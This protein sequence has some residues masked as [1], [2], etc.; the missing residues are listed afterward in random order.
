MA[1]GDLSARVPLRRR[2][3]L[4]R[5]GVALNRMAERLGEIVERER[6]KRTELEQ[7]VT[8]LR[9]CSEAVAEGRLE[10]RAAESDD[11]LGRLAAGF[12]QMVGHVQTLVERERAIQK[13][14][15]ANHAVLESANARLMEVDRRKSDFLNTVSHELRTPLTSIKAFSEI[16]LEQEPGEADRE[17]LGIIDQEADRLTRL[18]EDLLDLSRIE[19]GEA[20]GAM[21][22]LPL[23]VVVD[24]CL[25]SCRAL[26]SQKGVHLVRLSGGEAVVRGDRDRLAQVVTNLLSNAIKFT[27]PGGEVRV[28]T[29]RV[30]GEAVIAVTDTGVGIPEADLAR[31]FE[32]FQQVDRGDAGSGGSGLGLPIVRSIVEAHRGRIAVESVPG[33]G[34]TF[35][36]H[37]PEASPSAGPPQAPPES[38]RGAGEPPPKETPL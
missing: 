28:E 36:V 2:D 1:N 32:K 23:D 14:L 19:D 20:V 25:R 21:V 27:S 10:V 35:R 31:I 8:A 7:R 38:G 16:L 4:G 29:T 37:L 24:T 6:A 5:L 26:A 34:S 12:N 22:R 30:G 13:D 3:E 33:R 18:I 17:F 9:A 11:E 15:E